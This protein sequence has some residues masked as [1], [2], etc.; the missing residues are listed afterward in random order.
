MNTIHNFPIPSP[1]YPGG[2]ARVRGLS[3]VSTGRPGCD[4]LFWN[5]VGWVYSPTV[6]SRQRRRWARTPTLQNSTNAKKNGHNASS[7]HLSR[8]AFTFLEVLFAIMILGIGFILVAAIFPAGIKQTQ[9]TVE[10]QYLTSISRY[11]LRTM[12]QLNRQTD[13]R[14]VPPI[15]NKDRSLMDEFMRPRP[16]YQNG[17]PA[18]DYSAQQGYPRVYSFHDPRMQAPTANLLWW[19][20]EGLWKLTAGN[21]IL[22]SDPRYAWVGF[23]SRDCNVNDVDSRD[24]TNKF[25]NSAT[26]YLIPVRCRNKSQFSSDPTD[27]NCDLTMVNGASTNL[28]PTLVETSINF[29]VSPPLVAVIGVC[30]RAG[31]PAPPLPPKAKPVTPDNNPVAQGCW[32]IVSDD[33]SYP[34]IPVPPTPSTPNLNGRMYRIGSPAPGD[35]SGTVWQITDDPQN[36]AFPVGVYQKNYKRT[37]VFIVGRGAD[38]DQTGAKD[39][40]VPAPVIG[41]TQDLGIQTTVISFP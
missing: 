16:Q 6:L 36:S 21:M 27:P 11:A 26:V 4:R 40:T 39:K 32:L 14:P 9:A 30:S 5:R 29:T 25:V 13:E 34:V 37:F 18:P 28:E 17:A 31:Q 7:H 2:R 3:F 33:W 8:S 12:D 20:P 23:F 38:P 10:D 15:I 22:P 1:R 35:I 24:P 19:D 41:S